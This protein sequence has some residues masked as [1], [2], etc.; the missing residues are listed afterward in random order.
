M[1]PSPILV[2]LM[3]YNSHTPLFHLA[4]CHDQLSSTVGTYVAYYITCQIDD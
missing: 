1:P 2:D 4:I 3:V